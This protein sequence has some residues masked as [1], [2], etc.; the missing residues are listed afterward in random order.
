MP[1][2]LTTTPAPSPALR[3][4]ILA[5]DD[6]KTVRRIAQEALSEFECDVNEATNGFNALFTMERSLPD[7]ILLDVNMPVMD[8]M[9]LLA[10]LK[11]KPALH[12][13]PVIMLTS[14]TD[15]AISGQLTTLGAN[16]TVRKPFTAETLVVAIRRVI[17]LKPIQPGPPGPG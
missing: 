9:E 10:L 7:L 16:G 14:A 13:I 8:G 3:P 11:S 5:V 6:S 4:Q 1:Q 15:H 17:D 12:A 2:P